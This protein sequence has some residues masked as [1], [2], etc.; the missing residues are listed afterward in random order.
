MT[1]WNELTI[2]VQ[3]VDD[4]DYITWGKVVDG[5]RDAVKFSDTRVTIETKE[6]FRG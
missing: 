5:I 3:V 6:S 4:D 1:D 2:R